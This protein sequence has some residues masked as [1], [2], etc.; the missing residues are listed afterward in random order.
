MYNGTAGPRTI[1]KKVHRTRNVQCKNDGSY[2]TTPSLVGFKNSLE[3][4][5]LN[6]D[7]ILE[8]EEKKKKNKV[9]IKKRNSRMVN[10]FMS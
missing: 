9:Y 4:R 6:N 3:N 1:F 8:Q 5:R 7:Q 10:L 2:C